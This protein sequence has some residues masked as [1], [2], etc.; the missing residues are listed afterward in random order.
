MCVRV[1]H[2]S[3]APIFY[4]FFFTIHISLL[5]FNLCFILLYICMLCV[6]SIYF[7][8]LFFFLCEIRNRCTQL[9]RFHQRSNGNHSRNTLECR[10]IR[11]DRKLCA[12]RRQQIKS[13]RPEKKNTTRKIIIHQF[14]I[15][16]SRVCVYAR[17]LRDTREPFADGNEITQTQRTHTRMENACQSKAKCAC[18]YVTMTTMY[19]KRQ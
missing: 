1:H 2:I 9:C 10:A 11:I 19:V 8:Y 16:I 15:I 18:V 7:F 12:R 6:F 5:A 13:E 3:T 4:C 17:A 14:I